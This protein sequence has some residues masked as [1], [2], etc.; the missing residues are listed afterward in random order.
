MD[1]S[2]GRRQGKAEGGAP[3]AKLAVQLVF[4]GLVTLYAWVLSPMGPGP[5]R[6]KVQVV[7]AILAL[8]GFGLRFLFQSEG[9]KNFGG[10]ADGMTSAN[11]FK[12][13]AGNFRFLAFVFLIM[14]VASR[15]K[16][17]RAVAITSWREAGGVVLEVLMTML[18]GVFILAYIPFH[19]VVIMPIAYVAYVV[20]SVPIR[21]IRTAPIDIRLEF[22]EE[23]VSVKEVISESAP[24]LKSLAVAVPAAMM[25]ATLQIVVVLG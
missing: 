15:S 3:L 8:Y 18:F 11:L 16:K 20:V 1:T 12:F 7:F 14:S 5:L 6:E 17:G 23:K 9:L 19:V 4:L 2:K 21:R 13:L 25:A 24:A 10:L 22:G